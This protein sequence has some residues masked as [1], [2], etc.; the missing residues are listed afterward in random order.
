MKVDNINP[1]YKKSI[2]C[3]FVWNGMH[4]LLTRNKDPFIAFC[5]AAD[6]L[7]KGQ[8]EE[9]GTAAITKSRSNL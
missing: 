5:K 7:N 9:N 2:R 8:P 1:S 3:L 6:R 4:L